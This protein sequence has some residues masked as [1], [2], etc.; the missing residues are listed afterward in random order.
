[1]Q[2]GN[3]LEQWKQEYL[4]MEIPMDGMRKM[5]ES[6]DRA[7]MEK[8]RRNR[9]RYRRLAA[10][11]AVFASLLVLPNT[12]A[13]IAHAMGQMPVLGG[14]FQLVTFRNYVYEDETHSAE[15]NVGQVTYENNIASEAGKENESAVTQNQVEQDGNFAAAEQI[16]TDI[17][18][19]TDKLIAEFEESLQNE[20]YKNLVAY[21]EV[22]TDNE[23]YYTIRLSVL[24][25]EASG[26]QFYKYYTIDKSLGKVITL[27]D[28]FVEGSDYIGAI[29]ENIKEQMR[30]QMAASDEKRYFVDDEDFPEDNF[31]TIN[32]DADFYFNN[33]GQ[34]VIAFDEYEVAPG[35]MGTPEFVIDEA[36]LAGIYR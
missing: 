25:I 18:Q 16:N 19:T 31:K 17:K 22:V 28:L 36:A 35:Y 12:N 27:Q 30:A 32:E 1:M 6:I 14:F 7:K 11:A 21:T 3:I 8:R 5:Q 33:Q 29:S 24:E 20:G 34:L 2:E 9:A 13:S 10:S 26:Y 15:V 4:N 23:K